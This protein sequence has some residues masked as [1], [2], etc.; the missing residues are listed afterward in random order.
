MR[1][2]AGRSLEAYP[3]LNLRNVETIC[4][5]GFILAIK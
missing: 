3:W 5:R 2:S 1:T 4:S